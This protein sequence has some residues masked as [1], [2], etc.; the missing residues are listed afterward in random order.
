MNLCKLGTILG[1]YAAHGVTAFAF[2]MALWV[3]GVVD[4]QLVNQAVGAGQPGYVK[5]A[6]C[7]ECHRAIYQTWF[8][9]HHGWAVRR[10]MAENVLGDFNNA[11]FQHK[12]ITSN[13]SIRDGKYFV[14]TDGPDGKMATFQV[15]YT[16]GV[17]PLQQYLVE[18]DRG[19]LQVLDLAWYVKG[20]RWYH[21]KSPGN[22]PFFSL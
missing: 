20:K 2:L 22:T 17:S 18:L 14:E 11:T 16:V 12:G 6:V 3:S 21:R 15:K 1:V 7:A 10:P 19:R 5:A 4:G 13:F 8:D 9:S